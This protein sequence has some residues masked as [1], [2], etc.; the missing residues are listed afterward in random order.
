MDLGTGDG[1]FVLA[2]AAARPDVLVI[3]VDADAGSM[4]E[5]SRRAARTAKRGALPRALFVVAAAEVLPRELDGRVDELTVQFP[6]GSLLR[7]LLEA[8]PAIVGGIARVTR[9]GATVTLLLSV[10]ERDRARIGRDSVD[11]GT[12]RALAPRYALHGLLLREARPATG[13]EIARSH[14][15]WAKKLRAGDRRPVWLVRFGRTETSG[16]AGVPGLEAAT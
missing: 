4:A 9:P 2:T 14:S 12:F 15:T 10:T 3:G 5:A 8:D 7:G 11:E 16:V 1:R 6:W 13:D